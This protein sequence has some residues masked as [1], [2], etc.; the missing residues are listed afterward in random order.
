MKSFLYQSFDGYRFN[1]DSIFLFQF[2]KEFKIKGDVLDIGTG[3]GILTILMAKFFKANYF[4]VEK[5]K[6]MLKY[7][8][9][10]FEVNK[11]NPIIYQ[12]DFIEKN[13]TKQFDFIIS[14]PPFYRVDKNKSQNSS[15]N[16]ARYEEHLPLNL[17]ASKV[18]RLLKPRGYFIFCYDA[19][20]IDEVL[21]ELKEYRLQPEVIRFVH[22]K[23]DKE[24]NIVLIAARKNSK[25]MT[26][27]LPPLVVFN[28]DNSYTTKAKE[29]FKIANTHSI[30]ASYD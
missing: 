3:V 24:A 17:L 18:S 11:V 16:I 13:I 14:N 30:K 25:A 19:K 8:V 27:V 21:K 2:I 9:K 22:P 20:L 4:I 6:D 23:I 12:G 26:K 28:S 5:Q 15:I 7:A 1:S 29:A 10:N